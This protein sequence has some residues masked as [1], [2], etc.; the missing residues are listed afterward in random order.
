MHPVSNTE[1][2]VGFLNSALP[3]LAWAL[4]LLVVW[5]GEGEAMQE[6]NDLPAQ[7]ADDAIR[8]GRERLTPSMCLPHPET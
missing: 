3:C 7:P 1:S 4:A 6:R 8:G 2:P 5:L